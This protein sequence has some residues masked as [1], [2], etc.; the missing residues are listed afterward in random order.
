LI[1]TLA[2]QTAAIELLKKDNE[3]RKAREATQQKEE[4]NTPILGN[5]RLLLTQGPISNTPS[6]GPY[7]QPNGIV[8]QA[9]GF[10]AF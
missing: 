6:P 4:D 1:N 3:E 5:S 2:Q 10:R 8:P 9:T 7:G